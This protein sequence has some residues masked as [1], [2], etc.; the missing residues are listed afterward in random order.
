[1]AGSAGGVD[2]RDED[3]GGEVRFGRPQPEPRRLPRL[4]R[5]PEFGLQRE[6]SGDKETVQETGRG[7]PS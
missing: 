2:G 6:Q 4:V 7:L 3:A 5:D 1:M